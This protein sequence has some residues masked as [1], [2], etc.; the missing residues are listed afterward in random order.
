[1]KK[2][3]ESRQNFGK[4]MAFEESKATYFHSWVRFLGGDENDHNDKG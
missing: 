1:M 3:G 2:Q 4:V